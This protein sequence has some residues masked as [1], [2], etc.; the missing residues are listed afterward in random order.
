MN[1]SLCPENLVFDV[2]GYFGIFVDFVDR[3]KS[4]NVLGGDNLLAELVV[5]LNPKVHEHSHIH[6]ANSQHNA[7]ENGVIGVDKVLST[8]Q[9]N[10]LKLSPVFLQQ[11]P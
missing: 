1:H 10:C 4:K 8:T 2:L 5:K 3:N 7:K 11:Q 6:N 9:Q